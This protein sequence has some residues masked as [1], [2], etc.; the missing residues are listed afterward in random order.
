VR[1]TTPHMPLQAADTLEDMVL[2]NA[3]RIA[4]TIRR[5]LES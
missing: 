1:I 2:P 3:A 4:E 5:S